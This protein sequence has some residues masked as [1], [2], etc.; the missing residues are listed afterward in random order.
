MVA[1]DCIFENYSAQSGRRL[2]PA[3]SH[4]FGGSYCTP[5]DIAVTRILSQREL[6]EIGGDG[7]QAEA[8]RRSYAAGDGQLL[9]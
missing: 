6:V 1:A 5:A 8:N 4:R 3:R 2:D 7:G 9:S